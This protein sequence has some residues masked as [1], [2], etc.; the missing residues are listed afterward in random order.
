MYV[1]LGYLIQAAVCVKVL[2]NSLQVVTAIEREITP[3]LSRYQQ[4]KE[5]Q[6]DV[7]R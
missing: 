5:V 4:H 1:E 3:F 6:V 2:K 7:Y